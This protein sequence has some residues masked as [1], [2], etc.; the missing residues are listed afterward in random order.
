MTLLRITLSREVLCS[1]E[2]GVAINSYQLS[3]IKK[4]ARSLKSTVAR[5]I[6]IF[7]NT[8]MIAKILAVLYD[9]ILAK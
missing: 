5:T 3:S 9:R 2:K 6:A 8:G 7:S 1:K 4:S